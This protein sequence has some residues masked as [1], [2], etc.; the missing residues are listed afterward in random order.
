LKTWNAG[1]KDKTV[2]PEAEIH[3]DS[4]ERFERAVDTVSKSGPQH[5]YRRQFTLVEIPEGTVIDINAL[6]GAASL[7]DER[8]LQWLDTGPSVRK[9]DTPRVVCHDLRTV[10]LA[11]GLEL[12]E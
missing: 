7:K 2:L 9:R 1:M 6:P 8:Q 12:G 11:L 4:W 3:P 5:R 10:Y